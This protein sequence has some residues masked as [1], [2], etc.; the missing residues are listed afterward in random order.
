M[1]ERAAE[2]STFASRCPA[3]PRSLGRAPILPMPMLKAHSFTVNPFQ[4]NTWV[5]HSGGEALLI[6]PGC[7]NTSEQ[8]EI[9]EWLTENGLV[10]NR[11]I[12]TH[13]H[14]D[15][16]LG[17]AWAERRYGLRP[18][19]HRA[20]LPLLVAAPRQ[21]ELYGV[22]CEAAPEP[23]R[24]IEPGERIQVDGHDLE[25]LFVPGHAP[26]HIALF[27]SEE[28]FVIAG[29]VLFQ[30][31]IGRTDLPGGDHDT[32]IRSIKEVLLPL[33]DDVVVHCGHGN[34]TTIGRER[35][36]NPFLR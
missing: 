8:R 28:R 36:M 24:F 19:V 26:G 9:E 4:E 14:I 32:L 27:S 34:S 3:A 5:V 33:G 11:L 17:C 35:K 2:G 30:G 20:D 23:A 15:H 13:A 6:D 12:L 1:L 29:D 16:V 22:P 18:E 25:V 7:A 31:S 21:G 10:P